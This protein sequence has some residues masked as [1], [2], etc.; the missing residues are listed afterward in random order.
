MCRAPVTLGGGWTMTKLPSSLTLPSGLNSG[1][2]KPSFS[3]QLYHA[4]STAMG[5]YALKWGSSNDR[6][7]F[8]SPSGVSSTYSGR[9]SSSTFFSLG[10]FSL[11]ALG[12]LAA[13]FAF[14]ASNLACFSA[15]L[16]SF[17]TARHHVRPSSRV[18]RSLWGGCTY[19]PWQS[20]PWHRP[21]RRHR[22]Q[23]H[24]RGQQTRRCSSSPR[25]GRLEGYW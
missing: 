14:L 12:A 23:R 3:H 9:G 17:S 18:S 10:F 25:R 16:R 13:A 24:E 4:D 19:T 15:F 7:R 8:F 1:L 20:S 11:A 6:I 22:H 21:R 2:K 5:L